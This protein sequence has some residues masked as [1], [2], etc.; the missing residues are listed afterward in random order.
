[1]QSRMARTCLAADRVSPPIS[2]ELYRPVSHASSLNADQRAAL[3][4]LEMGRNAVS[5]WR[6]ILKRDQS[7]GEQVRFALSQHRMAMEA[8]LC[9]RVGTADF[10]WEELYGTLVSLLKDDAVWENTGPI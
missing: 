5:P 1:M 3:K 9:G 4:L 10:F 7:S 2:R 6:R 8:E